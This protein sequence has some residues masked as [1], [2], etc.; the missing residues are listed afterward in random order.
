M[1]QPF[2]FYT[3]LHLIKL[4]GI[5]AKNTKELLA[6]IKKVPVASIY[7]H[8]HRFLHQ[9]YYLSPE[10]PNDFAYWTSNILARKELGEALA[11][12][13]TVRFSN[14][15]D[16]RNEFVRILEEYIAETNEDQNCP[17]GNEFHFMSCVTFVLPTP[18]L[19]YDLKEFA[20]VLKKIS[21]NSLYFHIFEAKLRLQKEENDFSAWFKMLG[22]FELAQAVAKLD[23]YTITLEGLRQKI[24]KLVQKY[25]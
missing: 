22:H 18:Y 2:H 1:S 7:H 10:P 25:A 13:E 15:N 12:V 5:R 6:G 24:I 3:Q 14:L 8:T 17:E 20:E 21:I 11:G 4:T 16:L 9:H 19:A 23:P